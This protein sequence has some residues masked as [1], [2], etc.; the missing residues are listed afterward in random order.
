MFNKKRTTINF[1]GNEIRFL[2]LR[3]KKVLAWQSRKL[4]PEHMS[5]GMIHNTKAAAN[6]IR[7]GIKETKGSRN[8]LITCVS[9]QRAVHRIMRIPDI[10]D[11]MLDETIER[12]ARQEFAIPI[13][14]T[15][16]SW[17][18]ITRSDNQILLYVLAVPKVV[19][20]T[21]VQALQEAKIKPRVMDIKALALQRLVNQAN[22]LIVNLEE[23]S[24]DVIIVVNH[25][26]VLIRTIPLDT[27]ELTGEAKVDLLGQE[28]ARTTKY[29]NESNKKNRL[30]DDTPVYICGA[31]FSSTDLESRLEDKT[32]L[33]ER[34][35]LR[36]P[37]PLKPPKSNLDLP[38]KFPL[39]RYAVNLGLAIK[40]NK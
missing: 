23:Y 21:Q 19:I 6:I 3:G 25:I 35:Q 4:P 8:N 11:K 2:V 5:Q 10:P 20:D 1:E 18:I 33:I 34:F 7:T 31:L 27:G 39:L 37:Y 26:P 24:M 22:T 38:D 16:L 12:K 13:E 17:R 29:Y 40:G 30:A 15:D 9:G 36:T 28:L 14:D 32:N